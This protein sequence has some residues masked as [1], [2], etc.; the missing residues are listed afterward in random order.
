MKTTYDTEQF[1]DE[2]LDLD[3]VTGILDWRT[4][5]SSLS[6]TCRLTRHRPRLYDSYGTVYENIYL[7][8]EEA[9]TGVIQIDFCTADIFR[10][11]FA[12]GETVPETNIPPLDPR[13]NDSNTPMV[14]GQFD[15][16][17]YLKCTDHGELL[18]LTTESLVIQLDKQPWQ[19]RVYPQGKVKPGSEIFCTRSTKLPTV[20]PDR[21]IDFDPTWNF[22]TRFAYPLGVAY[23]ENGFSQVFD[24]F[25]MAHDEHFFGFGERYLALDKRGQK[26]HLWNEEVYS[27]TSTGTYKS[28]PFFMSSRGYGIFINTSLPVTARMGDLTG[29]AYSLILDHT[30]MLDYYFIYGPTFKQIL[31]RYTD[32]TG[33]P[34]LPPKWSFGHWMSRIT[35]ISQEEVEQ[36]AQE[37]RQHQI[38]TDV[39]HID[40]GWFK[41]PGNS[42]LLFDPQRF[43]D[44]AGMCARLRA[45]GFRVTLWQTPNTAVANAL[46]NELTAIDGLVRR[47][48][49]QVY[50][51]AGYDEDCGLIDYS[52]PDVAAF[53]QQKFKGLFDLGV[54]AIKVDF[55][56]GGPIDG[57]YRGYPAEAMRNL[58]ALLYNQA[59]F[60]ITEK[61]FG[62]GEGIIWA[63]ST[64]AGS[65]RYPVHWSGDGAATWR[66]LPCTLRSGLSFGLSGFVFW[67]HDIGGFIGNSSPELYARWVQVGAFSSHSRAHG[68]APREPWRY[69]EET[70]KIYRK[71]ME[72]RYRLLPYIYTQAVES[73]RQSLPMMRALVIDDQDDP[74]VAGI[75]DEYLF[76]EHLLVAPIMDA[77]NGRRVYLPAGLWV[78][79]WSKQTVSG[80]RWVQVE[81][82][83]DIL[84][85]WVKAGATIPMGPVQQFVDEKPLDPLT[86]EFYHPGESGSLVIYDQHAPEIKVSYAREGQKLK[87]QIDPPMKN[88]ELLLYGVDVRSASAGSETLQPQVHLNGWKI[89]FQGD[90][91]E[92]I[93]S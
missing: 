92:L 85:M 72:L 84:P 64:W 31:P 12:P 27:N 86:L 51:R 54:S 56:E 13:L 55:G 77:S 38:P 32:I 45:M 22:Y 67:S 20:Q 52:N 63:R 61:V 75:E 88:V 93:L 91:A 79:Y 1:L 29:A 71:Y 19:M 37:L 6:L 46:Y 89:A 3:L 2:S 74:T 10:F 47:Q 66:D 73:V 40:T 23:R 41:K 76:G 34:A 14:V 57:V 36:V 90:T 80:G 58:Y 28:I 78:D 18:E 44:P 65:Q 35:Y 11:R 7:P 81:A 25:D 17:V 16:P 26:L 50:N 21:Q 24:S 49:G 42:D 69:G 48:D 82:P 59:V 83:L 15:Q 9:G 60:E 70:E 30:A 68:E 39:I 4:D 62:K 33:K 5:G 87:V 53:M 43:P 8:A